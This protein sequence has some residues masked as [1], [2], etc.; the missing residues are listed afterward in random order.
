MSMSVLVKS[1]SS[2]THMRTH[3]QNQRKSTALSRIEVE[4]CLSK[5][6]TCFNAQPKEMDHFVQKHTL[7]SI[8][9]MKKIREMTAENSID[10]FHIHEIFPGLFL[11]LCSEIA[12]VASGR[13]RLVNTPSS[14]EVHTNVK[15]HVPPCILAYSLPRAHHACHDF[16]LLSLR[17]VNYG[18]KKSTH[19]FSTSCAAACI[20]VCRCCAD[21]KDCERRIDRE[22][23]KIFC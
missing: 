13:A 11:F 5:V 6:K 19:E 7:E 16:L 14:L 21:P 20:Y 17:T 18:E 22:W 9:S 12:R 23:M 2:S 1:K 8:S 10:E 3:A 15:I 4:V